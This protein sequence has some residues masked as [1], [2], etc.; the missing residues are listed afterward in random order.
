MVH[1]GAT[2]YDI[3]Q[4]VRQDFSSKNLLGVVL[5]DVERGSNYSS[6][7]YSKYGYGYGQ[8]PK[9]NGDK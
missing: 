8:A 2:P 6:Y 1:A 4:R 9:G 5:N 7:Y 3:A